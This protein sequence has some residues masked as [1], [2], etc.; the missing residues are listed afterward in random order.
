MAAVRSLGTQ[1][2]AWQTA[3]GHTAGFCSDFAA[4]GTVAV[5]STASSG[6]TPPED[7][8]PFC[9]PASLTIQGRKD[10]KSYKRCSTSLSQN[11]YGKS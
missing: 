11:G 7:F 6:G 8:A 3:D 1:R 10:A 5:F 2:N 4:L 9:S